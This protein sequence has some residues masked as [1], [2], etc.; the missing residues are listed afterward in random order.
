MTWNKVYAGPEKRF[1]ELKDIIRDHIFSRPPKK[2]PEQLF[3]E[4]KK[5]YESLEKFYQVSKNK[6]ALLFVKHNFFLSYS[7]KYIDTDLTKSFGFFIKSIIYLFERDLERSFPKESFER[8]LGAYLSFLVRIQDRKGEIRINSIG[9]DIDTLLKLSTKI[10]RFDS[11]RLGNLVSNIFQITL[12]SNIEKRVHGAELKLS[13]KRADE[14]D[15]YINELNTIEQVMSAFDMPTYIMS[16]TFGLRYTIRRKQLHCVL[17]QLYFERAQERIQSLEKKKIYYIDQMLN[18]SERSL[19]TFKK[20]LKCRIKEKEEGINLAIALMELDVL[21]A[22][23]YDEAYKKKDIF[24]ALRKMDEIKHFLVRKYFYEKIKIKSTLM[25]YFSRE[26]ALLHIFS[27]IIIFSEEVERSIDKMDAEWQKNVLKEIV[28]DLQE[29]Q[30][31]FKYKLDRESKF[32]LKIT[33]S[34]FTGGFTEYFIHEL[35]Q[36]FHEHAAVD[37]TSPEE[38]KDLMQC[39]KNTA[40]VEDIKRN[41]FIEEG[42][43]DIDIHVKRQ[44]A[45]FIKNC[46]IS[47]EEKNRIRR[48]FNLCKN[49][50]IKKIFYSINFVKNMANIKDIDDFLN[51]MNQEYPNIVF[52]TFDIK[53]MVEAF[54]NELKRFGKSKLNFSNI[55]LERV[56]YH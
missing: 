56:I 20:Y 21:V 54:L 32:F 44:G 15:K 42:K 53:D 22:Q 19:K 34:Q 9:D 51:I 35:F 25:E 11:E 36:E 46:L 55:E 3:D 12:L 49:N 13:M 30:E 17:G 29:K 10:K 45:V 6:L 7:F 37:Q 39:V 38:F 48:E 18:F 2:P 52:H 40:N 24:K 41:D 26:W 33:S 31:L 4:L 27:K 14:M 43:P 5:E 8:L 47:T 23:Y 1:N 16:L 28:R 50:G